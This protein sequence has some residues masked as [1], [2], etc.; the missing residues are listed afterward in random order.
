MPSSSE[1]EARTRMVSSDHIDGRTALQNSE[2]T[3]GE[4]RRGASAEQ[5][6]RRSA[7]TITMLGASAQS[8]LASATENAARNCA[9][10]IGADCGPLLKIAEE[11]ADSLWSNLGQI[12]L[13][14]AHRRSA[15]FE[16]LR[17][18]I[19]LWRRLA[20]ESIFDEGEQTPDEALLC[21]IISDIEHLAA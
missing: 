10:V 17:A 7:P 16:D 15:D 4:R 9:D 5:S 11:Q 6:E 20:P 12:A 3:A 1:A 18:K 2:Q 8:M 13:M 14:L 21:S 19:G